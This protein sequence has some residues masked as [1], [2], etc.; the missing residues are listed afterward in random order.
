[1]YKD[2]EK[3]RQAKK[4]WARQHRKALREG[5]T[6][7][8]EPD[9]VNPDVEPESRTRVEPKHVEPVEPVTPSDISPD[10]DP[11]VIPDAVSPVG[12]VMPNKISPGEAILPQKVMSNQTELDKVWAKIEDI[13]ARLDTAEEAVAEY[14]SKLEDLIATMEKA[15]TQN[16]HDSPLKRLS[17]DVF[18]SMPFS[19]A[20]QVVGRQGRE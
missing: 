17:K 14:R 20:R 13:E 18:D 2:R 15:R 5:S 1:M 16:P 11:N 7:G 9:V 3:S 19:K 10:V 6:E 4:E 12:P 8:V